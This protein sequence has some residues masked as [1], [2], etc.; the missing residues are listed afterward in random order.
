MADAKY[1]FLGIKGNGKEG[2][3]STD[4]S[5]DKTASVYTISVIPQSSVIHNMK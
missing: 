5:I 3:F 2:F 1:G 4:T